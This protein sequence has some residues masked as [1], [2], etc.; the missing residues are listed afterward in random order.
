MYEASEGRLRRLEHRGV[1]TLTAGDGEEEI[2]AISSTASAS[3]FQPPSYKDIH[4]ET[5][6][7]TTTTSAGGGTGGGVVGIGAWYQRYQRDFQEGELTDHHIPHSIFHFFVPLTHPPSPSLPSS[8]PLPLL[9]PPRSPSL[10]SSLL[11]PPSP[12]H[13]LPPPTTTP[14]LPGVLA[15]NEAM[16][17]RWLGWRTKFVSKHMAAAGGRIHAAVRSVLTTGIKFDEK[18]PVATAMQTLT[19]VVH[20]MSFECVEAVAALTTKLKSYSIDRQASA[21]MFSTTW[22][23]VLTKVF[24]DVLAPLDTAVMERLKKVKNHYLSIHYLILPC[25]LYTLSIH[26]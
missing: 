4:L 17:T 24:N 25:Y 15:R 13:H 2:G 22:T 1:L 23:E 11:A 3:A 26:H 12:L 5:G 21:T 19:G 6:P 9:F 14:C 7:T 10:F 8:L 18:Q 20:D 16:E